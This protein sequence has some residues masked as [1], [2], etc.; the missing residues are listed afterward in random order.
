MELDALICSGNVSY[1]GVSS[2]ESVYYLTSR[3]GGVYK[4]VKTYEGVAERKN[5]V[6]AFPNP[7]SETIHI[8]GIE[9]SEVNVYNALGQVVKT[10]LGTNEIDLSGLAEGVYLVRI[11]DKDGKVY[12]NKIMVQ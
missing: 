8:E 11:T 10:V 3:N 6:F 7:A 4:L 1:A 9:A 5:S 12:T 2:Y